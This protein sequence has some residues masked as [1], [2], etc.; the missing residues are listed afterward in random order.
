MTAL[1]RDLALAIANLNPHPRRRVRYSTVV[2]T[3]RST[4]A[5]LVTPVVASRI[6]M[7]ESV[8]DDMKELVELHERD[9]Q[10]Y[11]VDHQ[12][13][14]VPVDDVRS[15][16]AREESNPPYDPRPEQDEASTML[17]VD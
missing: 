5:S 12:V 11:S 8:S 2:P 7:A 4:T 9:F 6:A 3:Q 15:R 1:S 17:N 16:S 10:K 14:C 13:Y